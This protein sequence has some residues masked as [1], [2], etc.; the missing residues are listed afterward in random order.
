MAITRLNTVLGVLGIL[1]C[2]AGFQD[3]RVAAS[4]APDRDRDGI[5]D[6]LEER[7]IPGEVGLD[8]PAYGADPDHPDVFVQVDWVS[9]DPIIDY[10]GPNNSLDRDRMTSRAVEE[11]VA[12]FAPDVAVHVDNGLDPARPELATLHGAWG[13]ARRL[14]P[15]PQ[16]C[17]PD[18]LGARFGY[19]HRGTVAGIGGGG[20]GTL[21]GYCFG[22]NTTRGSVAAHEL[23][24][25]FGL[26]HGGNEPSYAANCKPHYRSPMNYAYLYDRSLAQFSR[27]ERELG[28]NPTAM[29]EL[30]GVGSDDPAV[31]ESL[32]S[33]PW[34]YDVRD[35][36]AIDW[37]RDGRFDDAPVRA[38]VTWGT[39]SCEQ[40]SQHTDYFDRVQAP[41]MG[42]V[43][44]P[45]GAALMLLSRSF[46]DGY[47]GYRV[48]TRFD[49]CDMSIEYESCTDWAP[50]GEDEPL[51]VPDAPAGRG[52]VAMASWQG[53]DAAQVLLVYADFSGQLYEQQRSDSGAGPEW[54]VP[55]P[56]AG[57]RAT[58]SPTLSLAAERSRVILWV[59][60][61]GRWLRLERALGGGGWSAPSVERWQDGGPIEPC[62]GA[63]VSAGFALGETQEA[64]FAAIPS[65]RLC[66]LEIARRTAAGNWERLTEQVWGQHEVPI[67]GGRPGL[68]YVP[69]SADEPARGRFYIA[70]KPLPNG[71]ARIAFTTGNDLDPAA[72]KLR[73]EVLFSS[74]LRNVWA[75]VADGLELAY[76]RRFDDNLRAAY[77]Y[78]NGGLQFLPFA[79]G[80][81]DVVMYDQ[82]D[83]QYILANL[84]CSL[85]AT[86]EP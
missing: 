11:M 3:T 18:S 12:Y 61:D 37:N 43:D 44:G 38:P 60:E 79:D 80:I 36:G 58:G 34:Y 35:D 75:T 19:F 4:D 23:G 8:F 21:Y 33:P 26:N 62:Y 52:A 57:V 24:H 66:R 63:S 2:V 41:T 9:C 13:G 51:P 45:D 54:S 20:G 5:P 83:Y 31:L 17:N 78:S 64:L 65:G 81:V 67:V 39:T 32:R 14:A 50:G 29:D 46:P 59:P 42:W 53:D 10:C 1:A 7:G 84:A 82:D 15:G 48:A 25:N 30:S 27:G 77:V 69:V 72:S 71:G 16:R 76:D 47:P 85:T 70:W 55:R 68:A 28:L 6:D 86:C 40:S 56:I 49:D 73:M 22:A 74:Y